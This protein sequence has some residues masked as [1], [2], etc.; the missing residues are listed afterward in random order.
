MHVAKFKQL[1]RNPELDFLAGLSAIDRDRVF[2]LVEHTVMATDMSRHFELINAELSSDPEHRFRYMLCLAMKISDLSNSVRNFKV[3]RTF[4]DRLKQEF[5]EQGD[6]EKVLEMEVSLGMDRL[7]GFK[8]IA[9]SQID[10]F[11]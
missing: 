5:Y 9:Q 6:Q 2:D 7:E 8:A 3:H 10:F 11:G 1:M 4:V